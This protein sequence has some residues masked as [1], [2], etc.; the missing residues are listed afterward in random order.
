MKRM[1]QIVRYGA[2]V[3]QAAPAALGL[4]SLLAVSSVAAANPSSGGFDAAAI[5]AQVASVI[6]G[7]VAMV[8]AVGMAAITV[9]LAIQGF[10]M[11]WSM[12]K[13]VK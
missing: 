11:A 9:I 12:I 10:K 4:G 1:N 3:K 6:M 5:G 13:G 7:F 2:K 8:S